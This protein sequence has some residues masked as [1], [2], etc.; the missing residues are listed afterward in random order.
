MIGENEKT[1]KVVCEW[2]RNQ[3]NTWNDL[4][5]LVVVIMIMYVFLKLAFNAFL[6]GLNFPIN[7]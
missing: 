3:N 6:L 2:W 1:Q 4:A 5:I 7:H